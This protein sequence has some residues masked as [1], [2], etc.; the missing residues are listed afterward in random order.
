MK[1]SS[2]NLKLYR[3]TCDDVVERADERCEVMIDGERCAKFI[4]QDRAVWTNFAH[5]ETRNGKSDEWIN[6]PEN[7][8]FTCVEHHDDE[9][10]KGIK[11]ERCSYDEI[12]YVPYEQ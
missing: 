3:K 8:I 7:I 9:H 6:D 1:R 10:K 4:G 12:Y 2:H 11:L 5:T